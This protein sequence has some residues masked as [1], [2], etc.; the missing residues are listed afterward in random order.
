M[1]P[2]YALLVNKRVMGVADM[3]ISRPS[4]RLLQIAADN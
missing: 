2:S 4:D 1:R 3:V